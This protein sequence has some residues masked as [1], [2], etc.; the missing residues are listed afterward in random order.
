MK[1]RIFI[2]SVLISLA[3]SLHAADDMDWSNLKPATVLKAISLFK[4]D[5]GGTNAPKAMGMIARY[6]EV[7]TNVLVIINSGYMPWYSHQPLIKNGKILLVAFVAGNL[8]PQ[9]EKQT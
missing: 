3:G 6:S 1:N 8:K 5:P 7:S 4:S 2:T 9:L